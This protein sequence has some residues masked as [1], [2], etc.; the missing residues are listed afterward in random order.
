[1]PDGFE[2]T[3]DHWFDT[4]AFKSPTPGTFGN[5]AVGSVRAPSRK[6]MNLSIFRSFPM[7]DRRLEFR[8]E[9][10]NTFNWVGLGSPGTSVDNP[11]T[12]GIINSRTG[13]PRE[14]QLAVKFYF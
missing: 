12:F 2:Q 7:G 8:I 14:I 6:S 11:N 5:C 9:T 13:D 4:S 10:F 3:I 1:M